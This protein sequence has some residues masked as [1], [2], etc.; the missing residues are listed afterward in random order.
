VIEILALWLALQVSE[1]VP[2]AL[3]EISVSESFDRAPS[4]ISATYNFQC[5]DHSATIVINVAQARTPSGVKVLGR[6]TAVAFL[7]GAPLGAARDTHLTETMNAVSIL[8][9]VM[10]NCSDGRPQVYF[11]WQDRSEVWRFIEDGQ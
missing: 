4:A 2:P 11:S 10:P 9:Q 5:G 7:D 3:K 8:P 1:P 6:S